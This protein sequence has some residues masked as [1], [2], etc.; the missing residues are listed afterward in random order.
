MS[1]R[2]IDRP[3]CFTAYP[4]SGEDAKV[5]CISFTE[6]LCAAT[7][8]YNSIAIENCQPAKL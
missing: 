4:L 2:V 1:A 5:V 6:Y 7:I 3:N 8:G